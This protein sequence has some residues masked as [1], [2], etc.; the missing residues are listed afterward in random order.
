MLI[1]MKLEQV[2]YPYFKHW[3]SHKSKRKEV[4]KM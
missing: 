3:V 1:A 2:R 4:L